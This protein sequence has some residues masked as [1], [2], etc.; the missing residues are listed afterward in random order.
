IGAVL[1]LAIA[2]AAGSCL[3][4]D[5]LRDIKPVLHERCYACHGVLKQQGGLR[6]DTAERLLAG[7]KGG[8][9]A[10]PG[11]PDSGSLLHRLTTDDEHER[12]PLEAAPLKPEQI[13]AIRAWIEAGAP[14]PP[15]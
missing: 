2:W 3:A 7:G 11:Q 5:Y 15:D 14:V 9:V 6:L 12:M 13:A 4:A 10:V 1:S 8:P